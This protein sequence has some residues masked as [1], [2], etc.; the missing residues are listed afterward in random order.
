MA[1]VDLSFASSSAAELGLS[2]LHLDVS[3]A[4]S[5][6]FEVAV[7]A[8]S[9]D[10]DLDFERLVGGPASCR[11]GRGALGARTW[12]GICSSAEQIEVEADGLSTYAIRIVPALWLLGHR[13]NHRVFQHLS[14]PAIARALLGEWKIEPELRL[15]EARFPTLEYR[16]QHGESDLAFLGRLLEDAGLSYFFEGQTLVLAEAPERAPARAAIA[17]Q[18]QP[19]P[20]SPAP[21]VTDVRMGTEVKPGLVT[22]ADFDARRPDHPLAYRAASPGPGEA[23]LEH[24]IYAPGAAV[25]ERESATGA[26]ETPVADDRGRARADEHEGEALAARLL[27]SLRHG[28]REVA[29]STNAVDLAPGAVFTV[30]GAPRPELE[31][32]RLVVLRA[33]LEGSVDGDLR[34]SGT[35]TLASSPLRPSLCTPRPRAE[36]LVSAL[37]VGPPGEEIHTDEFGRVRLRFPWDREG[38]YDDR[39]S[40]WVRVSEGWA[41]A[42]FGMITL[43]RVGQEVL[44]AHDEGDPDRPVVVGRVFDAPCPAPHGLPAG[45]A[46]GVLRSRSSP[47]SDGFHEIALDDTS[48]RE[49]VLLRS[50]RDLEKVVKR[51]EIERTLADRSLSVGRHQGTTVGAEDTTEAGT[52]VAAALGETRRELIAGRITLTTGGATIVLDGPDITVTAAKGIR[53]Q[54]GGTVSI[55]GQPYVHLNPPT[56]KGGDAAPAPPPGDHVVW[57]QLVSGGQPLAGARCHVAHDDGTTSGVLVTDGNGHVRLP[58][59]KGGGYRVLLG[60]PPPRSEPG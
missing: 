52:M 44:V 37:V 24:R 51:D 41:G 16:A 10:A 6:P 36:G 35:A 32:Q 50:E 14:I 23:L 59:D 31:A 45:Q 43:P 21:F 20:I 42:A 2:V 33:S 19:S 58:V 38:A 27:A 12:T 40:P 39:R 11:V 46:R 13:R 25:I 48:G 17:F 53:I 18:S 54:A 56:G 5:T 22:I 49:L 1:T 15:D 55:Q 29:Y 60:P 47:G 26:D 9:P 28:R 8:V 57:F 30:T 7:V 4:I 34:I 3:E